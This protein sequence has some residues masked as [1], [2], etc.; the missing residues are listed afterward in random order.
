MDAAVVTKG[1]VCIARA[2]HEHEKVACELRERC[3]SMRYEMATKLQSVRWAKLQSVR[4]AKLQCG[5]RRVLQR[6]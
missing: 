4:W 5:Q 2:L 6:M 3:T 1:D